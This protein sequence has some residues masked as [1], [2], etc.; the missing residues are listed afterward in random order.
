MSDRIPL[1]MPFGWFRV[2]EAKDL[3]PGEVR[4]I[5]YLGRDMVLFRTESGEAAVMDAYCPHLG[6]HLGYGGEVVGDSIRCPFHYWRFDGSGEC[7]EVPYAR[8]IPPRARLDAYPTCEKNG[9]IFIWYHPD[10]EQP[11]WE[12]P[13]VPDLTVEQGWL[14]IVYHTAQ[15]RSHPQEMAENVVDSPHFHYVHGTP[16]IP[17]KTF[18]FDGHIMRAYQGLTFTTPDGELKG[19]VNIESHGGSIGITRFEGIGETLLVI[20]GTPIDEELHESIIRFRFRVLDGDA[21]TA[22]ALGDAFIAEVTRQH[23]QDVPIWEHKKFHE[24]PVLCDGDGPIHSIR[25]Y[26]QQFYAEPS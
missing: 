24:N 11:K 7:V 16:D 14:D 9:I 17:E 18:T 23:G 25:K 1:P 21:A 4:S 20:T 3:A 6:A 5:H 13:E 10:G 19:S 26:Y 22:Q 2:A 8:R 15:V 12:V